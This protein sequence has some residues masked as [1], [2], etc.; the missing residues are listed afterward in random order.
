[1]QDTRFI[2][3][4]SNLKV[5]VFTT[6]TME[7]TQNGWARPLSKAARIT[8]VAPLAKNDIAE[9]PRVLDEHGSTNQM[10][11]ANTQFG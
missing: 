3:V 11:N 2:G 6:T 7:I 5:Q 8:Q 1:M 9:M 4:H 10:L